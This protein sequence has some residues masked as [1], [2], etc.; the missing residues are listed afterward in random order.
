MRQLTVQ[1]QKVTDYVIEQRR[2]FHRNPE[3]G[4]NEIKTTARIVEELQKMDIPVEQ[5]DGITGCVGILKGGK[6][7]KTVMLRA[8]IDALPITEQNDTPYA[9]ENAGVMHA[10]GHDCHIAM[11]LGAAKI[12]KENQETLPGTVKLLFQMGEELGVESRN[13]V[14]VG[15]LNDVDALFGMHVWASLDVGTANFQM[16]ERMASSDRFEI[17]VKGKSA[18]GNAPQEG[19]DAVLAAAAVVSALQSIASRINA[20]SNTLVVTI[21]M[22]NGGDNSGLVADCV[23]LVGTVR[24]FDKRFRKKISGT[25]EEIVCGT[26]QAYGCQAEL[27]YMYLPS[28]VINEHE[29]LVSCAQQAVCKQLGEDALVSMIK[30][31]TAEDFSELMEKAPAVFGYLGIRNKEKG[32]ECSHHHPGF[33]VD[34]D[35]LPSGAGIYADFARDFLEE[36]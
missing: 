18:Q 33:C 32:I 14:R 28:P 16:G 2:W 31:M 12:L 36:K 1:A 23:E 3:L 9:S 25:M 17:T 20:P 11:L 27:K 30:A 15:A 8:D 34:E 4:R 6:P 19:R 13:Y 35:V 5:F 26:A 21:G 7:G 10:C 29:N 24:T 22:M